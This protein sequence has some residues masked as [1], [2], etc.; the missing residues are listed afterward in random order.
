MR[1]KLFTADKAG[2]RERERS[3]RGRTD[4]LD[5]ALFGSAVFLLSQKVFVACNATCVEFNQ[6]V[7]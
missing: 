1:D 5:G 6:P 2:E 7:L 3:L 4:T